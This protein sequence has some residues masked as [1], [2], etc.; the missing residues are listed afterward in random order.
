MG[1]GYI[2]I[3]LVAVALSFLGGFL[4]ANAF[5][6]SEL[7]KL[8]SDNERLRN[9]EKQGGPE[10]LMLSEE[11]IRARIAE[12]DA[13]PD[14]LKFQR[15]L[16]L[17]LYRYASLKQ[18]TRLLDKAVPL[19]ERALKLSSSDPEI[20]VALGNTHFDIGYFGDE[21][22]RFPQARQYYE[23]ALGKKPDNAELL[24]DIGL[25]Y[26]LQ[27]PADNDKA[28]GS[29][30]D[31]LKID[32]NHEKSLQFIIQAHWRMNRPEI[33]A[34][35]LTQLKEISPNSPSVRELTAILMQPPPSK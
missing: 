13:N 20:A 1:R 5:N 33:A 10:N 30:E 8:R 2:L 18:D 24:A 17:A 35:Y 29:F 7:D 26:F 25:T 21:P 14:D 15:N 16:G 27:S 28:I 3:S 6:R 31:A 9:V 11:E 32:R 12:A 22:K 19:L 23:K 34:K 4:L